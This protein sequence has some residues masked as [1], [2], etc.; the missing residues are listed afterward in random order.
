M[1][2]RVRRLCGVYASLLV[3]CLLYSAG[4]P[5]QVVTLRLA[6]QTL[7]G[8]AQ[9]DGASK[10]AELVAKKSSGKLAVKVFGD[11]ALG[12]DLQVIS[13]LQRGSV[14]ISLMNASLLNGVAK[15]FAILDFP[16][17]FDSE[18]EAYSVLDGPVGQRL[19]DLLPAK[20]IVG[21]SYPELGF[22]HIH[23]SKHP[24]TRLEDLQGLKI[25]TVQTPIYVE[26]L[27]ALGANAVPLPFPDLYHVLEK[28]VV[29]GATDPLVTIDILKFDEVQRYLTLT[30]H[31]YNPQIFLV[32]KMTWD[33]LSSDERAA[34]QDAANDARDFERKLSKE[35]NAQAL[36]KLKRTMQL[37]VLSPQETE[38]MRQAVRPVTQKYTKVVGAE[39]VA[40]TNAA[41][42][43]VRGKKPM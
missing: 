16:F 39:L 37:S 31:V 26:T 11:G 41:L 40:E 28:K 2:L 38:K 8:T 1:K 18:E 33:K 35:K 7:P 10:F 15:E 42:A 43:R 4:V 6:T 27:S 32:S 36:E 12:G 21:L 13:S 14:E 24:V 5:A 9:Y 25:R 19:I 23:N 17:L 30:H 29:D 20:G 3:S 34:L 22:R